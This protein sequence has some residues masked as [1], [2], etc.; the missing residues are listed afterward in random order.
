MADFTAES[1]YKFLMENH[2]VDERYDSLSPDDIS[3]YVCGQSE[4]DI[5]SIF[6]MASTFVAFPVISDKSDLCFLTLKPSEVE[7]FIDEIVTPEEQM[8]VSKLK[9]ATVNPE[10]VKEQIMYFKNHNLPYKDKD[11][12][13]YDDIIYSANSLQE[14]SF[15]DQENITSEKISMFYEVVAYIQKVSLEY[16]GKVY[17]ISKKLRDII[18]GAI[19]T[20]QSLEVERIADIVSECEE[21]L[22]EIFSKLPN[23]YIDNDNDS[24]TGR[25]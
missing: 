13:L 5:K 22:K 15:E 3:I 21:K 20:N 16:T 11:N 25:R 19:E 4:D 9:I 23:R 1:L 12:C 6:K 17:P 24:R 7:K 2:F 8:K 18:L 10:M 14:I